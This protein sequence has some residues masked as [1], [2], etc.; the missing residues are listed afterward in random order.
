MTQSHLQCLC[1]CN[2]KIEKL[3]KKC[4]NIVIRNNTSFAM[5]STFCKTNILT[6]KSMHTTKQ[7]KSI[8]KT[9]YTSL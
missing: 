4:K 9:K 6:L 2:Q 3:V 7:I 8:R 5:N 1:G